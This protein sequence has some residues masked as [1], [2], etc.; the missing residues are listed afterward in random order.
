MTCI[1]LKQVFKS[2]DILP[3]NI[4]VRL[5]SATSARCRNFVFVSKLRGGGFTGAACLS[6]RGPTP[7]VEIAHVR[8]IRIPF[9]EKQ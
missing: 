5:G 8:L 4:W 1:S 9:S 3:E 6:P 7:V 2:K